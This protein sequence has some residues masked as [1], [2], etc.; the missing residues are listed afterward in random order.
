MNFMRLIMAVAILLLSGPAYA[1]EWIEYKDQRELF[2]INFPGQPTVRDTAYKSELG[3]DIPARVYTAKEGPA[4]YTLTV[5]NYKDA[6]AND[7]RGSQIWAAWQLRK[8]GGE[9]TYEAYQQTDRIAGIQIQITNKDSTR[10]YIGI[11]PHMRRLYIME[12]SAPPDYPPPA[13]FPQTISILDEQ[14]RAIRYELDDEGNKVKRVFADEQY[15]EQY[16]YLEGANEARPIETPPS[17]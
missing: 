17:Q 15:E 2:Q 9:V 3:E 8:R 1:Q 4:T 6:E 12:A 16:R 10:S 7:W 13:D 14:G 11:Y 5:V